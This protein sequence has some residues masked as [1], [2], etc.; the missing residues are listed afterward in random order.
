MSRRGGRVAGDPVFR[1]HFGGRIWA[2]A[3]FIRGGTNTPQRRRDGNIL[4][5]NIK[6]KHLEEQKTASEDGHYIQRTRA[7]C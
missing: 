1:Q 6:H 4:T 3:S 7:G 2:V 5:L